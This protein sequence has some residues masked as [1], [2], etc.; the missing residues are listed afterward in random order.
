MYGPVR[1]VVWQG[2]VGDRRP[3][4]DHTG[5]WEIT[6]VKSSQGNL[7]SDRSWNGWA[8]ET[9]SGFLAIAH[10]DRTVGSFTRDEF[11]DF[12]DRKAVAAGLSY[13]VVAHLRWDLR[14]I[15][16]MAVAEGFI[17]R[18]PAELLW[19]PRAAK[20]PQRPVMKFEE[21]KRCFAVLDPRSSLIVKLAVLAG[22][23]PGEIFALRCGRLREIYADIEQRVYRGDLDSPKTARSVRRAALPVGVLGD[24]RTWIERLPDNRDD[25]WVFPSET[26]QTPLLKDNAWRRDIAPKL[27]TVGLGWVNFHVLRRTHSSLMREL[28]VDP[29]TVADQLGHTVDVNLNVYTQT[30]LQRRK[31][32]VDALESAVVN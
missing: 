16:G 17:H 24:I 12:L 31:Q 30:S 18:N 1:T 3:Y 6:N 28:E 7:K 11:Q 10:A 26:M 8:H 32:A 4:A 9:R 20:Q 2:S 14:Q 25:A 13:S 5:L 15:F 19:V 27:K 29:K 21:V 22:M 23:R